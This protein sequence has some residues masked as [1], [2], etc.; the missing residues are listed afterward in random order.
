MESL[1]LQNLKIFKIIFVLRSNNYKIYGAVFRADEFK[2]SR[3]E[4]IQV[5]WRTYLAAPI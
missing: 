5:E 3:A 1:T 2:L 4:N